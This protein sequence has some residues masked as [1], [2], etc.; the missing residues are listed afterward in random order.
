MFEIDI[1]HKLEGKELHVTKKYRFTVEDHLRTL[2][3]VA[4]N[5]GVAEFEARNSDVTED[6][7]GNEISWHFCDELTEM[8]LLEE[9]EESYSVFF[10]ITE[11]GKDFLKNF[12]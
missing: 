11:Y 8:G 7:D 1:N 5:D 6:V 3:L 10:E 2:A 4:A 12:K 9:D